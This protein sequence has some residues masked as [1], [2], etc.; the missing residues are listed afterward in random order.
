LGIA[1]WLYLQAA[2][3]HET[4]LIKLKGAVPLSN[5]WGPL[6]TSDPALPGKPEN[7]SREFTGG[8]FH[9]LLRC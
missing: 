5:V 9:V 8:I 4:I 2:F 6:Y 7:A 3:L 1:Q